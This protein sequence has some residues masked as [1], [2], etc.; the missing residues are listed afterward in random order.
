MAGRTDQHQK[1]RIENIKGRLKDSLD[2]Y[3]KWG[4]WCPVKKGGWSSV[5]C[6]C[7]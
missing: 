3:K 1:S 6:S 4:Y 5:K 7:K 2:Q